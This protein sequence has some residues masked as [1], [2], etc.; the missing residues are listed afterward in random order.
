M[1]LIGV[2]AHT[3]KKYL[4]IVIL[5]VIMGSLN[6]VPWQNMSICG[7]K[8]LTAKKMMQKFFCQKQ[9]LLISDGL[10]PK[11]IHLNLSLSPWDTIDHMNHGMYPQDSMRYDGFDEYYHSVF[12]FSKTIRLLLMIYRRN[13]CIGLRK[14]E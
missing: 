2:G 9:Q 1:T 13:Q 6:M 14:C 12:D 8:S 3:T 11:K 5:V 10:L 7:K 4:A